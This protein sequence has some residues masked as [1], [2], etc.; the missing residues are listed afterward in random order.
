MAGKQYIGR[1]RIPPTPTP[2]P[3]TPTPVPP[4]PTPVPP[5]LT[6]EPPTTALPTSEPPTTTPPTTSPP[7]TAPTTTEPPT[8]SPPTS[9]PPTTAPPTS[10]PPTTA[11]PTSAPPT[12]APPTTA[13]P[14]TAPPTP[15]I[16]CG[17]ENTDRRIVNGNAVSFA[18]KYSW[19]VGLTSGPGFSYYCGGSIIT[20]KHILTAAH[21]FYDPSTCVENIP[22]AVYVGIGDHN[23]AATN[24]NHADFPA[25]IRMQSVSI[26]ENYHCPT[27]IN[28]IAVIELTTPIDLLKHLDSIHPICLPNDNS[29]TYEGLLAIISGWGSTVGYNP[30]ETPAPSFPNVLQEAQVTV[31]SNADCRIPD[32]NLCAGTDDG[33][34]TGGKDTCQGDSGG[35]IYV[36]ESGQHVQIGVVSY[37][38]GCASKGNSGVYARVGFFLDWIKSN[39]GS[40][41]TY[42]L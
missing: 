6:P 3:P 26:H 16:R 36:K 5:T 22:A 14:T 30:G 38:R 41:A 15:T 28:D 40:E 7:T 17:I 13:P 19:Q 29:N 34:E 42:T 20:D 1:Q 39:V 33:F 27:I 32:Q 23:W 2:V 11:L 24:D 8:S 25:P 10:A 37:G 21:C 9:A 35:P 4:T 18:R 12:T 31:R